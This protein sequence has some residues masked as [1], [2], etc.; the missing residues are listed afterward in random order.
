MQKEENKFSDQL[1]VKMDCE[2]LHIPK[3]KRESVNIERRNETKQA[4]R[5]FRLAIKAP[6]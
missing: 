3:G 2:E 6:L 5:E 1:R 4:N